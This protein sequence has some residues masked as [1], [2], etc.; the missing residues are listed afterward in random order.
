MI[1]TGIYGQNVNWLNTSYNFGPRRSPHEASSTPSP[2]PV[3]P[4]SSSRS[5]GTSSPQTQIRPTQSL[6][7]NIIDLQSQPPPQLQPP[8]SSFVNSS[9]Q[10]DLN[11]IFTEKPSCL[12][13]MSMYGNVLPATANDNYNSHHQNTSNSNTFFH[14]N[15]GNNLGRDQ[16]QHQTQTQS[17]QQTQMNIMYPQNTQLPHAPIMNIPITMTSEEDPL[18]SLSRIG[19][20][21]FVNLNSDELK[22]SNLT[23]FT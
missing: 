14:V 7:M 16:H 10:N 22:L 9:Y 1:V 15:Q 6:P 5:N 17:Q 4:S 23:I 12:P 11:Q 8:Q 19:S 21:Q 20:D 18:V 13:S 2:Q 3:S